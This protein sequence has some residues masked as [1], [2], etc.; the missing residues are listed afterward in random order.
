MY[1]L[2]PRHDLFP[3][4][5]HLFA[6]TVYAGNKLALFIERRHAGETPRSIASAVG[7]SLTPGA[8]APGAAVA[9]AVECDPAY[10]CQRI[11]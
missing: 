10:P 11:R 6:D 9:I 3:W 5:R 1:G 7:V 4:L 2:W 8:V